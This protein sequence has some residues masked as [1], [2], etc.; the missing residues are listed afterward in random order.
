[1]T[2]DDVR[3]RLADHLLATLDEAD[4]EAMAAH[5][6][7]CAA[8]RADAAALADGLAAFASASHDRAA[9]EELADRVREVLRAEWTAVPSIEGRSRLGAPWLAAAAAVIA[10]ALSL[11][12]GLNERHNAGVAAEQGASYTNLLH[13]LGGK[14]FRAGRLVPAAGRAVEGSVVVYD[15]HEDQSWAAV[16]VRAPGSAGRT[17]ATLDAQDGR[18]I[19]I[20]RLK[21]QPDGD[22]S[23]WIVTSADLTSFDHLTIIDASGA[24]LATAEIRAA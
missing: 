8:C 4:T 15:S 24:V 22:G 11:G 7:G 19:Q 10:V 21:I 12:W 5:L 13:T 23:S 18:T 20:S 3:E 14:E 2:C 9:P 16:F 17:T 1:M 6:R